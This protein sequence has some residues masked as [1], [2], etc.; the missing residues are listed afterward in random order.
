[1]DMSQYLGMFIE[2]ARDHI[3]SL[4]DNMLKLEENPD[5]LQLINEIFRSAHTL[6]G[7]AGTMGFVN[8]QKLTHAMENVLA[9]ARDG[10]LKINSN[11]MDVL[12][13]TV[14]A[15]EEYLD[16]IVAT[17]S[18]GTEQNIGLVNS[19]N[20][21]LGKPQEQTGVEGKKVSISLEY[22]E[23]VMRA[24]ERAHSQGFNV[25]KL[26]VE[27]DPNCLLKSARAYLVFK[28][29]EELGEIIHS[30]PPVQDIED[31]KF[32]FEFSITIVSKEPLEKIRERILSI[33][34][35]REVKGTE[36]KE[37]KDVTATESQQ[38]VTKGQEAQ[39][40]ET[41]KVVRE[42]KQAVTKK[43]SQTVR[44]DI[45]RLDVLM[46]LVSELII[47]KSRIEG[48]AKRYNGR[49]F[50]ESIEY[51]ERI[52][53]SL[54]DAVMKVRMVPVE[55]VFS[56]FPRM[57]RDLARELGKEFELVMSGED[58]EIDRTIV[59][60]LGDPLIH[61]LRNAADHGIEDPEERVRNGKPRSGLIKLSAYHDG[62]N[63]VIE[64][65]DDGK[66][67]DI[68]KV[69]KK[70]IEKGLLKEDQL[71]LSDQEV[72]DFLFLP[73]FSTK[74]KVTN[75][76]GRGVGLDVVKT[77]IEQLGGMIEV[78]TEKGKGTRFVIR[79]PLTLAIIQALLV[80]VADEIY[81]IPIASIKEIID[82]A[83][84]DIKTVQKGREIIMLRNQV[85]PIKYL[86]KIVGRD[87]DLDKKKYTVVIVKR[88]EKLTG[89]IVDKLLGQQ[90]IVIKSLGK[91][92]EGIKLVSGAT[93]LGDG[94]VAMI[95]DPN[96]LAAV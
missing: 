27:L 16:V 18:E 95:L 32:D 9:A 36:I 25:Y 68:E 78:N 62:N 69:K 10:K 22:D 66:G 5:N 48:L 52:T 11:I 1:M 17:G 61:L 39:S 67:I 19:L 51:L 14:D 84:E 4:N 88:G 7:M 15:L 21:I 38:E 20:S 2:E 40:T 28:A 65:E 91:Y 12:F 31:E 13:K 59:D 81:A 8:M 33:S 53:T 76:S 82:I 86:H 54:H 45:E 3:Q 6:K 29:V 37:T 94:S 80:T 92:L 56:R 41:V 90:D 79:L 24:I 26:D 73:S 47:I 49:Q 75:L 70:A 46:N 34:E 87:I 55:R 43:T 93:I 89:I 35:I 57:M 77:K 85:I 23:F 64:V 71:D 63:V 83:K 60:E 72:I 30:K 96:V 44:V 50:E 74:D 42:Q 58:T